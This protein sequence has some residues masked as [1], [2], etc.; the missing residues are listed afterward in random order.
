MIRLRRV[1]AVVAIAGVSACTSG[2]A[3]G[4][5][6]SPPSSQATATLR[7][8][9]ATPSGGNVNLMVYSINSDSPYYRAILDG[10]IGD[11]GPA[12]SVYP[13]GQVDPENDS[14]ME[15]QLRRGTFR[16][17]IAEF[18]RLFGAQSSHE[19]IFPA[20]CSDHFAF[21]TP[22]A[23]VPGSGTGAYK[24]I[25]GRFTLTLTGDEVEMTPCGASAP[26]GI[27][28]QVLVIAGPGT[29]SP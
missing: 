6:A 18:K 23:I 15:L 24:G 12:M 13:N 10:A 3:K 22:V 5:S 19:P 28:W 21:T 9:A 17:D 1:F 2:A 7:Q 16:L 14:Q 27:A 26:G 20:T 4:S 11:F 29:V 25:S 8:T